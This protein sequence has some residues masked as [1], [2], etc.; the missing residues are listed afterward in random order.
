[1]KKILFGF[2]LVLVSCTKVGPEEV[3]EWTTFQDTYTY[4]ETCE[5]FI[6]CS[7]GPFLEGENMVHIHTE[8]DAYLSD[9]D[10]HCFAE[11]D[12]YLT[13]RDFQREL[14]WVNQKSREGSTVQFSMTA[15]GLEITWKMFNEIYKTYA[16][17]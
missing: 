5:I 9:K 15:K 6:S 12:A 10:E 14:R 1:M 8:N 13:T 7:I 11:L 4:S 16:H 17:N 2:L 3:R